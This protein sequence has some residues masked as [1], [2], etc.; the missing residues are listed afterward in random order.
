MVMTLLMM[1][2][3][4]GTF[5]NKGLQTWRRALVMKSKAQAQMAATVP[6]ETEM[7]PGIAHRMRTGRRWRTTE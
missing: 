4:M 5:Q 7:A 6:L 2:R 1:V 3:V